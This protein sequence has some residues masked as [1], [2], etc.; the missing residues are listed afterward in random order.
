MHPN[1]YKR[2]R[3]KK[4]KNILKNTIFLILLFILGCSIAF[5]L[6]QDNITFSSTGITLGGK[7]NNKDKDKDVIIPPPIVEP[8]ITPEI[9]VI[10]DPVVPIEEEIGRAHV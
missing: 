3:R 4:R 10:P 5:F 9:P 6:T 8:E 1:N 7:D 2:Y